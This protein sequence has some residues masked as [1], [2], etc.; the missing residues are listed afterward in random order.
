MK[1]E[2]IRSAITEGGELPVEGIT[3][4]KAHWSL[5]YPEVNKLIDQF[6]ED[7]SSLTYEQQTTLFFGTL[8][9]AELQYRPALEKV[10]QLFSRNDD[11]Q[12]QLEVIFG[13]AITELTP[14]IFYNLSAGETQPLSNFIVAH[15]AGM[16]CKAAAIEAVFAMYEVGAI[17]QEDLV[18]HVKR[19]LNAFLITPCEM[20]RFLI[21][22]VVVNCIN[23]RL[24][25]F[26][27]EFTVLL[28]KS[29]FDEESISPETIKAWNNTDSFKLIEEGFVQTEFKVI[30]TLSSWFVETTNSHMKTE[31]E[32]ETE[33]EFNQ[34]FAEFDS[35]VSEDGLLSQLVFNEQNIIDNSVPVS[36]LAK[37]GRNDPCPCGSG[38]KYKKCCLH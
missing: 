19:W 17:E 4:A 28:D 8:I 33:A 6:I 3:A 16:Y 24:D 20:N 5:F 2:Q 10:L 21:S 36:S 29:V 7:D 11:I 9:A 14:S 35:L 38:K 34:A 32:N 13:D 27:A 15:H 18:Q 12:S 25:Q 37:A 23:Y 26:K 22:A 31:I 1:L 30:E